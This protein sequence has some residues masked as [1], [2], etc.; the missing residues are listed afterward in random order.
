M[1]LRQ[2]YEILHNLSSVCYVIC[3]TCH[4]ICITYQKPQVH[5]RIASMIKNDTVN[6]Y[7]I[8]SCAQGVV[9]QNPRLAF[10]C[11]CAQ[12]IVHAKHGG[13]PVGPPLCFAFSQEMPSILGKKFILGIFVCFPLSFWAYLFVFLWTQWWRKQNNIP[14]LTIYIP[15]LRVVCPTKW[16]GWIWWHWHAN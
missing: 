10:C 11:P 7:I 13:R 4:K 3:T 9:A 15:P 12:V 16:N 14:S 1:D 5:S 6:P 8:S 2:K